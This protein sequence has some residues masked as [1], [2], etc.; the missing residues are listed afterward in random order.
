MTSPYQNAINALLTGCEDRS[1]QH[2]LRI[3]PNKGGGVLAQVS[4]PAGSAWF[5]CEGGETARLELHEDRK[6]P[7]AKRLGSLLSDGKAE[8]LGWRPGKRAT[9]RAGDL[10]LKGYRKERSALAVDRYSL[11]TRAAASTSLVLP[12]VLEHAAGSALIT[13]STVPGDPIALELAQSDQFFR[14]GHGL[15]GF[16]TAGDV[17]TLNYHGKA[18]EIELLA[19][20]GTRVVELRGELPAGWAQAAKLLSDNVPT[21]TESGAVLTHRDLHDGQLL[22]GE[23]GIGLLDFDLLCRGDAALDVGNLTAHLRLRALQGIDGITEG[24]AEELATA[25]L[26]GLDRSNDAGFLESLR[27]YQATTFLRLALVYYM[28]PRWNHVVPELTSLASR[29]IDEVLSA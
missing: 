1:E 13:M 15:R 17:S 5:T 2:L 27:F 24:V 4:E 29:C 26:E 25:L 23:N 19:S 22:V 14:L 12:T 18:A 7:A 6:L 20:L 10:I 9:L 3:D 8:L 11:A 21:D 28:R 16:Q